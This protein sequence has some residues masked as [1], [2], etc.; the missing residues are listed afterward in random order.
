M[1]VVQKISISYL[2]QILNII[3]CWNFSLSLQEI[4]KYSKKKIIIR[5]S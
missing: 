1:Y 3:K 5:I 4:L 2:V